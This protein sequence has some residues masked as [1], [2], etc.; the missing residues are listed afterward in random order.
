MLINCGYEAKDGRSICHWMVVWEE[1]S[2]GEI[3]GCVGGYSGGGSFQLEQFY[4]V[5][6]NGKFEKCMIDLYEKVSG[7]EIDFFE[8]VPTNASDICNEAQDVFYKWN[9]RDEWEDS[10][11]LLLVT[12]PPHELVKAA[13]DMFLYS[14]A[15]ADFIPQLLEWVGVT[16]KPLNQ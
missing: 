3:A 14:T 15:Y 4:A 9:V 8:E 1:L 10:E 6:R 11:Q 5:F 7:A 13:D 2:E 12:P 16:A